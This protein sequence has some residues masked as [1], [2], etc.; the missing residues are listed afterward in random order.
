MMLG[1]VFCLLLFQLVGE[2]I[3]RGFGLLVRGPVIGFALR[4]CTLAASQQ[5]SGW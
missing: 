1:A 4:A 3:A 5:L 2:A